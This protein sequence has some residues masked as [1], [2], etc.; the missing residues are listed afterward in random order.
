MGTTT[1]SVWVINCALEGSLRVST[2]DLGAAWIFDGF[3][4][5][6]EV[7]GHQLPVAEREQTGEAST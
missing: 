1:T 4:G 6:A 2:S 7:G 3:V 5:S